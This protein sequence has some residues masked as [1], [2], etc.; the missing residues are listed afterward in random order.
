[1]IKVDYDAE[2][3]ALIVVFEG[4]VDAAQAEWAF[5]DLERILPKG[6]R[7]FRLLSDYS[8]V[9]AMDPEVEGAVLKAMDFVNA[10]G[11]EEIVRV[12]P[13]PEMDLGFDILSRLHYSKS[14]RIHTVRSRA[15]A[16]AI[17]RAVSR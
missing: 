16:Q 13:D 12:L 11:V 1:M 4:N 8:A 3:N 5:S 9:E 2:H 10:H 6:K 17:L 15:E 7:G 14:V